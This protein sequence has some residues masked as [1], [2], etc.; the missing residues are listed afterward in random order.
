METAPL[1]IAKELLQKRW[2]NLTAPEQVVK[3]VLKDLRIGLLEHVI[4]EAGK[5]KQRPVLH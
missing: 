5:T 4:L 1:L 3:L 2:L